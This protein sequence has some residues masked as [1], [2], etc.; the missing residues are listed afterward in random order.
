MKIIICV[1]IIINILQNSW[2]VWEKKY[3]L[4]KYLVKI[5]IEMSLSN[6]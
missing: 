5:R 2:Y 4:L 3:F 6:D 1:I